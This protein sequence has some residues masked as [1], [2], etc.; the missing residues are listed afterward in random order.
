MGSNQNTRAFEVCKDCNEV[1]VALPKRATEQ[2]A[3]YDFY[4]SE[5]QIIPPLWLS[6]LGIFGG[7]TPKP[8]IVK[9]GV[10]AKLGK[11]EV[12]LLFNRSSNP[13]KGLV[14]ANGVGVVDADYYGNENNDGNIGFA[15]FNLGL[16]SYTIKKGDKI[17]QGLITSFYKVKNDEPV[18]KDRTGGFGSTGK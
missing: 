18:S 6:W 14:L 3:G 16:R 11:D 10:K 4:A 2:S 8:V 9:T 15:F 7:K 1:E 12:L 17:G 5:D 13:A